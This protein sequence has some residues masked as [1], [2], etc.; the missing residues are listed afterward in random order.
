MIG[1]ITE[2]ISHSLYVL[3][4]GCLISAV[5]SYSMYDKIELCN[6]QKQQLLQVV[7]VYMQKVRYVNTYMCIKM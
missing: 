7:D 6:M 2:H 1:Y 3:G 4:F 5:V